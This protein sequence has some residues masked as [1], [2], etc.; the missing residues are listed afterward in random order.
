VP[1]GDT[2]F[3]AGTRLRRALAGQ[4]LT[5]TEFRVPRYATTDLSGRRLDDVVVRGKHL[6]FRIDGGITLHTHFKMEGSWHLY[7]PH[8]KWRGPAHQ[9]RVILG[10]EPWT[11]VGFRLPVIDLVSTSDEDTLVGHLGPD[12]LGDSWDEDEVLRRMMARPDMSIAHALLDQ[13]IVAGLGNVYRCEVC[14][15]R[16]VHPNT[17]VGDVQDLRA[18][19]ALGARTLRANRTT[20]NQITTGVDRPGRRHWVYG[21]GGE[22]CRRCG[23]AIAREG[24]GI[25]ED[26]VTYWCPKCQPATD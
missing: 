12:P 26:R 23:T 15:L 7:R 1:E 13:T 6:L 2:V 17:S 16:G 10:T 25:G 5:R 9:V 18:L 20:G 24:G 8:E 3:L 4:V 11:A 22:P 14:F 21:R 19:V